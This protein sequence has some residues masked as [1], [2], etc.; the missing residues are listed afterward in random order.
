VQGFRPHYNFVRAIKPI[1]SS[2]AGALEIDLIR[3]EHK[4]KEAPSIIDLIK[5]FKEH[6]HMQQ[7]ASSATTANSSTFTTLG[8]SN[9]NLDDGNSNLRR[10]RPYIYGLIHQLDDCYYITK[11]KR[12]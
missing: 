7:V 6:H 10:R 9:T 8:N 5:E 3:K 2:F 12:P 11:Q 1:S 4:D